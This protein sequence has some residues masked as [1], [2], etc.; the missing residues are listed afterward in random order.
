MNISEV[1]V[2]FVL[3]LR[4]QLVPD[5]VKIQTLH[6]SIVHAA[7]SIFNVHAEFES[8]K[9]I[10]IIVDAFHGIEHGLNSFVTS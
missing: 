7:A 3:L 8:G 6:D 5:K 1:F 2:A 10:W 9:E 4:S